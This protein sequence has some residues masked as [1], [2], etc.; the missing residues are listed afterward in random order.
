MRIIRDRFVT[1]LVMLIGLVLL[2]DPAPLFAAD[3]YPHYGKDGATCNYLVSGNQSPPSNG[4][5][6][7]CKMASG[8]TDWYAEVKRL[9]G[10]EMCKLGDANHPQSATSSKQFS[11]PISASNPTKYYRGY[12]HWRVGGSTVMNHTDQYFVK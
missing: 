11:C 10:Q 3:T 12:I 8:A 5:M 7:L 1:A 6:V 9:D 2:Y 4:M